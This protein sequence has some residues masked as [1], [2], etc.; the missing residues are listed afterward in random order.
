MLEYAES[1]VLL[2][3]L[4][5]CTVI[6]ELD[7]IFD[8]TPLNLTVTAGKTAVLPCTVENLGQ[9][10]MTWMHPKRVLIS[11]DDRRVIDDT[12]MS[13]ERP[14]VR[15][16]NLHIRHIRYNDSGEYRCTINTY[17]VQVKRIKLS[18]QVSPR[19]VHELSTGNIK[20]AE[21]HTVRLVC[22]STGIPEPTVRWSRR[23][24][25]SKEKLKIGTEGEILLIHNIS[26]HCDGSYECVAD[27]HVPPA[28]TRRMKV[29]VQFPP[30]IRLRNK[31]LWQ[32]QGKETIL[33]CIITASPQALTSW[34]H[35]REVLKPGGSK[36]RIEIYKESRHTVIHSVSLPA[37]EEGDFGD[38]T[39]EAS[40]ALGKDSKT[41]KLCESLPTTP[42]TVAP[43]TTTMK[44]TRATVKE[45]RV[46]APQTNPLATEYRP[47]HLSDRGEIV[48]P[49]FG[50]SSAESQHRYIH[51]NSLFAS[52]LTLALAV[53]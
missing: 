45:N 34:R 8:D 38:Y 36:Y 3:I 10:K 25:D 11:M 9:H 19:I 1:L 21:G 50:R 22:N 15:D 53:S 41:M 14:F 24:E 48:P 2:I 28:V 40:N 12:R 16:W 26:R 47:D 17:P 44:P 31:K 43:P 13:I 27:N 46:D 49:S 30:E 42:K 20:V 5:V 4:C 6:A 18:V 35:K 52:V 32:F 39:C 23:V 33:E 29:E 37:L 51:L 7:P